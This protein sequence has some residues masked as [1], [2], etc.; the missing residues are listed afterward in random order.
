M[1]KV[2]KLQKAVYAII[3]G[4]L[5]LII[6]QVMSSH[7]VTGSSYVLGLSGMLLIIGSLLFLYPIL[8]AKKADKDGKK[9]ELKAVGEETT[10]EEETN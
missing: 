2:L 7:R 8:F 10:T 9:V 5:S 3:L 1:I 4:V 6:A